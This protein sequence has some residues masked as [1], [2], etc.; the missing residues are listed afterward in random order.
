MHASYL[1]FYVVSKTKK[2]SGDS[3]P[4]EQQVHVSVCHV[5]VPPIGPCVCVCAC[6][7]VCVCVCMC[8]NVCMHVC[9]YVRVCVYVCVHVCVYECV[10]LCVGGC[11]YVCMH[12]QRVCICLWE[13]SL[14][15]LKHACTHACN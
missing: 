11:L 12:I 14:L 1:F 13:C 4:G 3:N 2:L 8:I 7:F 6:V 15:A 10:S 5:Y 9:I